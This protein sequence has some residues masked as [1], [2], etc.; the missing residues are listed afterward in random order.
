MMAKAEK[1]LFAGSCANGNAGAASNFL[2]IMDRK[3]APGGTMGAVLPSTIAWG[4]AWKG[5]RDLLAG[6]YEDV[7][8][9]SIASSNVKEMSFSFDTGMGEVLL[10]ATKRRNAPGGGAAPRGRFVSLYRRP[11]SAIYSAE[12]AKRIRSA[13]AHT[14][15]GMHYAGTPASVGEDELG[16]ILDC[17]LDGYWWWH[18]AVRD[19]SLIQLSYRLSRGEL[20]VPGSWNCHRIPVAEAGSAFGLSNRDI[21]SDDPDDMRAPFTARPNDGTATYPVLMNNDSEEQTCMEFKPDG[22]AVPKPKAGKGKVEKVARTATR[23]HVNHTCR[24]TS[25]RVLF[26]YTAKP[27]LASSVFP[28]FSVPQ[29]HEKAMAVWGNSTLGM[30]CFWAHA[31]KQQPG[32]GRASRTSMERM[33]VLDKS[34]MKKRAMARFERIFDR[35]CRAEFLPMNLCYRDKN[36]IAMDTEMLSA[37]GIDE[38]VDDLRARLCRE[39]LVRGGREDPDL[40]AL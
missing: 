34:K 10:V 20:Q 32:R 12:L 36:R 4:S 13:E 35:Y 15:D 2:A 27:T 17:P 28:S 19:P 21:C 9:V 6:K 3:L 30:I 37:L 38:P 24:Y 40:D 33:P 7:T 26:P 39:P 1:A 31:G 22:M 8:V 18:V 11:G 29:G 23:L 25:Q 16:S 14:L 5:C